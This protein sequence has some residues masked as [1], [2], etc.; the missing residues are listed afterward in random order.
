MLQYLAEETSRRPTLIRF[1]GGEPTLYLEEMQKA[2]S[3]CHPA[4]GFSLSTNGLLLNDS[5]IASFLLDKHF[6]LTVS[7]DGSA[8]KRG[9]D[10]ILTKP[11]YTGNLQ[12]FKRLN[13][14]TTLDRENLDLR[15]VMIEFGE[16]SNKLKRE[17]RL[18]PHTMHV[19]SEKNSSLGLSIT[20]AHH[21]AEQWIYYVNSFMHQFVSYGVINLKTLFLFTHLWK[22][23]Q[24]CYAE[25]Q[26]YCFNRNLLKMD[27][28]GNYYACLY[29]RDQR[30]YLG[31]A[32]GGKAAALRRL[33]DIVAKLTPQCLVCTL[34]SYCGGACI[35]SREHF[36]ECYIQKKILTWFLN[37]LD[38][39]RPQTF[40]VIDKMIGGESN[41]QPA[42]C[43]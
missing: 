8:G 40:A 35:M 28:R 22:R 16:I 33:Q 38:K 18:Y 11:D 13:I 34:Y 3:C 24:Q 25:G 15:K 9:Y 21:Y 32:A 37:E 31:N 41:D 6:S 27:T 4:T 14:S 7:Y 5:N 30:T 20:D 43:L 39:Y 1:M 29:I 19:T 17:I 10:N 26:T 36:V 42:V 2:V 12:K 23:S